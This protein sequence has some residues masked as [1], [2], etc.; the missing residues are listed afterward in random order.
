MKD[1]Y[2]FDVDTAGLDTSYQAMYDAYQRIFKRCGLTVLAC[3]ADPGIMGGDVSHEFMAPA[4]SG[5]DHVVRCSACGY[6]ANLEAAKCPAPSAAPHA[7]EQPKPMEAVKTPGKHTVEQVSQFLK[8][9]PANFHSTRP[10]PAQSASVAA[11]KS[12]LRVLRPS[13]T[14]A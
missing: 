13:E 3:E 6:A 2:S 10:V 9:S 7:A 1:A 12:V 8:V 11:S 4:E 5:E 14:S